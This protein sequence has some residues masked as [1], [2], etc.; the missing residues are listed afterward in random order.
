MY[1]Y[2]FRVCDVDGRCSHNTFDYR[3]TN[4]Y[5]QECRSIVRN[6]YVVNERLSYMGILTNLLQLSYKNVHMLLLKAR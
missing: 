5:W 2:H 3:I 4:L 1:G 6:K